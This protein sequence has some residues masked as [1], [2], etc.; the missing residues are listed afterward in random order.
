MSDDPF[1][2]LASEARNP[3]TLDIDQLPTHALLEKIHQADARVAAAI[4]RVLPD[5]ARAVDALVP[6]LQVGGRLIYLG[7]GTSGRLG[8]LDAAECPPTFGTDPQQI[9]GLI[10][11]GRAAMFI[12]QENAEDSPALG[13][14]DLA[15]LQL[16]ARDVVVGITASGCTPY[17]LGGLTYARTLG[18]CTLAITGCADG[19][20]ARAAQIAIAPAVGPEV[21]AGSSRMKAGT[22]QKMILNMLSTAA[23]I[24]LGKCYSNLMVDLHASNAKLAARAQRIVMQA[25]G[26]APAQAQ[27]LLA[28]C[29]QDVKLA[30]LVMLTGATPDAGRQHLLAAG[31]QLRRALQI[32]QDHASPP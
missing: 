21:I 8:V 20:V 23:M 5:I 31:G 16:T 30:I 6:A 22:A 17:V 12:A 24:R 28:Q 4:H 10:A 14:Q 11:G 27:A 13:Q 29:D 3:D 7:A 15:R 18:C 1:D 25:T 2:Q 19:P 26:A 32:A 9:V